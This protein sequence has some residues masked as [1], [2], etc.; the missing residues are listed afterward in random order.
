MKS[1]RNAQLGLILL[2]GLAIT[3]FKT[4]AAT[5][6]GNYLTY[7]SQFDYPTRIQAP[8]IALNSPIQGVGTNYKGE[9]DV[10][11]GKTN[12]V[13]WYRYGIAPG[14]PG[15]AVFDAHIF[16][17]FSELNR[18]KSGDSIYVTM[19]SGNVLHFVVTKSAYYALA[20]L[21]ASTLF[22][23]TAD[24][25]I[26]LITCAGKLTANKETYDHRLIVT[27]KLV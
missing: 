27:A 4:S 10:P 17:A 18:L 3:P 25:Q 15:T 12:N 2:L 20:N 24:R 23:T 9:M 22:A 26:N 7:T 21:A 16:A 1:I 11:S 5:Y 6:L 8:A 19:K 14:T 13:G